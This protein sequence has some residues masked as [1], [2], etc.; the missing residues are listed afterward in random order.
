LHSGVPKRRLCCVTIHDIHHPDQGTG[1][2]VSGPMTAELI[3]EDQ[4]KRIIR[5]KVS[6]EALYGS[7][8]ARI[9][10]QV[11]HQS[12]CFRRRTSLG[13]ICK[14]LAPLSGADVML[15]D[16]LGVI[17]HPGRQQVW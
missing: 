10:V 9:S 11:V 7:V 17:A 1:R 14:A 16:F 12:F 15:S 13:C 8:A 6:L 2:E 4:P 5:F 3:I